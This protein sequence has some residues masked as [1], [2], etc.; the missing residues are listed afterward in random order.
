M[1]SLPRVIEFPAN[2]GKIVGQ[3]KLV[4]I[5][6]QVG[7]LSSLLTQISIK[8]SWKER[9]AANVLWHVERICEYCS[10][11]KQKGKSSRM[12]ICWEKLANW[13]IKE[14]EK[15]GEFPI[16][17][18][19][20]PV[21]SLSKYLLVLCEKCSQPLSCGTRPLHMSSATRDDR[22]TAETGTCGGVT[23]C[24]QFCC[25]CPCCF[26]AHPNSAKTSSCWRS[27]PWEKDLKRWFGT[28]QN[29]WRPARA[30]VQVLFQMCEDAGKGCLW[31]S[32]RL[33]LS[34]VRQSLDPHG[35][36]GHRVTT[37]SRAGTHLPLLGV[38]SQQET[39]CLEQA[40]GFMDMCLGDHIEWK[41][42]SKWEAWG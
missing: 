16:K 23:R 10:G 42:H 15:E 30:E 12:Q 3:R 35:L 13:L 39:S 29:W 19:T 21:G 37:S 1:S 28:C 9:L 7:C 4:L 36:N 18:C 40:E 6:S 32:A 34:A 22:N 14:S 17:M 38:L 41:P 25:G 20:L 24:Y 27:I 11:E 8:A 2:T 31:V 33:C 5:D 26:T